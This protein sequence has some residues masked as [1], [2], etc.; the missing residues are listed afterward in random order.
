[1]SAQDKPVIRKALVDLS[2]APFRALV[3]QRAAW[4]L[5]AAYASPGPVQFSGASEITDEI[6]LT[7]AHEQRAAAA[8][9]AGAAGAPPPAAAPADEPPLRRQR[10][11]AR[12]RGRGAGRHARVLQRNC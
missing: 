10:R 7:L 12:A 6:T 8:S 3:A 1:M 9:A 5:S 2:G 4:E 11:A